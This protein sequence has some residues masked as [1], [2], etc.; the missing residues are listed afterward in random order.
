MKTDRGRVRDHNEDFII[1]QEP[2][3]REDEEAYGWIYI[4]A[5]G[6]G[7]AMPE[8]LPANSRPRKPW[9]CTI[10]TM[11]DH[12]HFGQRLVKSMQS[13]NTDLRTLVA[14]RQ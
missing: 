8:N 10:Q 5:D 4:V 13:A 11:L 1:W 3:T 7:G 12:E 14:E 6:V 2:A 9:S